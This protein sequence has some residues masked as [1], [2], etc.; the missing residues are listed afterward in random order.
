MDI[1]L[2]RSQINPDRVF[3]LVGN[4]L[5]TCNACCA[6][7]NWDWNGYQAEWMQ[8][9]GVE[10]DVPGWNPPVCME[11]SAPHQDEEASRGIADE[12]AAMHNS[13]EYGHRPPPRACMILAQRRGLK[14]I[15]TTSIE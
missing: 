15:E 11:S 6:S 2:L 10:T 4:V 7:G 12:V 3:A 1:E 14:L 13:R 9:P 8:V 5:I